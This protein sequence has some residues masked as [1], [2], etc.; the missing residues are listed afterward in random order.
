MDENR[1]ACLHYSDK[2]SLR[3]KKK[4]YSFKKYQTETGL[5][6]KKLKTAVILTYYVEHFAYFL[7]L[8]YPEILKMH[9]KIK[10]KIFLI[11]PEHQN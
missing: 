8:F 10:K 9:S 11:T 1:C 4:L 2:I 5:I 7:R 6:I 3:D